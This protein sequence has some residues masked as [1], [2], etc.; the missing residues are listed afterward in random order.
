MVSALRS[1][2]IELTTLNLDG[3]TWQS[4]NPW[5][6]H[7]CQ[8]DLLSLPQVTSPIYDV[9]KVRIA[10]NSVTFGTWSSSF[11]DG[12]VLI[13]TTWSSFQYCTK[14]PGGLPSKDG[15]PLIVRNKLRLQ[16]KVFTFSW[17]RGKRAWWLNP[18]EPLR[19]T[20]ALRWTGLGS[21]DIWSRFLWDV[22]L[23]HIQLVQDNA[24]KEDVSGT[25]VGPVWTTFHSLLPPWMRQWMNHENTQGFTKFHHCD[26]T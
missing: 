22:S 10:T 8:Y 24:A 5:P 25:S 18:R 26:K 2:H 11:E 12:V 1:Y 3:Q 13:V 7:I 19:N 16:V 6:R 9:I 14:H 17:V 4:D 23:A 21:L 20:S 15:W